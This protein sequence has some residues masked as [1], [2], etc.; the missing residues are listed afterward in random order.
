MLANSAFRN[1][2]AFQICTSHISSLM[3]I[4]RVVS[5]RHAG[6][7]A[8]SA[9]GGVGR[10]RVSVRPAAASAAGCLPPSGSLTPN[11]PLAT[12]GETRKLRKTNGRKDETLSMKNVRN[13]GRAPEKGRRGRTRVF[14]HPSRG[15]VRTGRVRR[16]KTA[17][18]IR[19]KMT[20][21]G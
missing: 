7:R 15:N 12:R 19:A 8:I 4:T 14:S 16:K 2:I 6:R 1:P 20:Y 10:L 3:K 21:R 11:P 18:I 17:T 9:L 5:A 13:Q